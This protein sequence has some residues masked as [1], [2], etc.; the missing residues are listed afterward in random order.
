MLDEVLRRHALPLAQRREIVGEFLFRLMAS[1]DDASPC[2]LDPQGLDDAEGL[3]RSAWVP[4]LAFLR[5]DEAADGEC[6]AL[7]DVL[8]CE[9]T[10]LHE[11]CGDPLDA[12][13]DAQARPEGQGHA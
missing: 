2:A 5:H 9:D 7:R 6:G 12:W 8:V 3:A 4:S 10:W 11:V 1:L 13:F